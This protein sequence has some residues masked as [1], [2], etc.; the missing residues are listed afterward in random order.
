[1]LLAKGITG[2]EVAR[3][4][5]TGVSTA[6]DMVFSAIFSHMPCFSHTLHHVG[7]GGGGGGVKN[8]VVPRMEIGNL[9]LK[10]YVLTTTS[11]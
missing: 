5:V 1:M 8:I 2:E 6:P 7:G 10:T 4:F 3:Q 9:A 11:F